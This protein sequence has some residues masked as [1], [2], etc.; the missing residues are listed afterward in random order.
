LHSVERQD[1]TGL[2]CGLDSGFRRNET[3]QTS[4][5]L[6]N[7][8]SGESRNPATD[9]KPFGQLDP[10]LNI[11]I[12]ERLPLALG[13]VRGETFEIPPLPHEK[14]LKNCL[15]DAMDKDILGMVV[16]FLI[17]DLKGGA[18]NMQRVA[19]QITISPCNKA[20]QRQRDRVREG[21]HLARSVCV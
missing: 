11:P 17:W 1:K 19:A 14:N 6:S 5:I 15:T 10:I 2:G 20:T 9:R 16:R 7:R 18:K 8:H 13:K 12:R 4:G 21:F 3:V